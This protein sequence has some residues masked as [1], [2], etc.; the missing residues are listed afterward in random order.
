MNMQ[1]VSLIY[2]ILC[3]IVVLSITVGRMARRGSVR[4]G[5]VC[6]LGVRG[7]GLGRAAMLVL[8]AVRTGRGLVSGL[9]TTQLSPG[10]TDLCTDMCAIVLC[11]MSGPPLHHLYLLTI[12]CCF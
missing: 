5:N 4:A 6:E 12:C 9:R 1:H 8:A 2:F 3:S 11:I 7:L 10:V